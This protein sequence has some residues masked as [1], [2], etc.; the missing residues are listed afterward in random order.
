MPGEIPGA[1]PGEIPRQIKARRGFSVSCGGKILLSLIDPVGQAE[2]LAESLRISDRTLYFCPSP[3]Y[4]YGLRP[5]L[6]KMGAAASSALLCVELDEKLFDLSLHH[7]DRYI[8]DHPQFRLTGTGSPAGLCSLVRSA[9][10]AR[11]FRRVEV[12][13]FSAGWRL[14]PERYKELAAALNREIA[15]DWGNAM[16]LVRL[17]RRY[18]RNALRNLSLIPGAA[19]VSDL[20]F[21]SAPVLALGAGPSLDGL[22]RGL[23]EHFGPLLADRDRRPFRILCVDTCLAS[24]AAR[25][26][27]PDLVVALESQHWNLRDFIGAGDRETPLAMDLS[28]LPATAGTL[29]KVHLFYTPWTE[30]RIFGRL[31]ASGL[32]PGR[33]LPLGS[34]GLSAVSI[35]LRLSRGPVITAGIDFSFTL[36]SYHA[37]AAAGHGEKLERQNRFR[38]ILNA[39]AAF[40]G[41]SFPASSKSGAAVRS[42]PS[43]RNYRDL[44]ER[45]FASQDRLR[46]TEGTGLPLGIPVLAPEALYAALAGPATG[47]KPPA[48]ETDLSGA[49][50][51]PAAEGAPPAAETGPPRAGISPAA[52][53]HAATGAG[54][55]PATGEKP[56]AGETDL[57]GAGKP[58]P[59]GR[60]TAEKAARLGSFV[61]A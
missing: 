2:R 24:L 6:E 12:L 23:A 60:S 15:L 14:F 33:F 58:P 52:E 25:N 41:A 27:R 16:T 22:L 19:A 38:G 50:K 11:T 46:D 36:D 20:S 47:E 35:A 37:R 34:V 7:I 32:L 45:E 10:G 56:P 3:L 17:G 1:S 40:R 13:R 28:A 48:G 9:W 54:K 30:L 57:S 5:L 26:I 53:E 42:D 51:P 8:L 61:S 43:L 18:I 55:P 49:G 29:G 39:D 4:G 44:F 21:G 31:E 59:P